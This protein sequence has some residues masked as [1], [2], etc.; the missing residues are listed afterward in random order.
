MIE[1]NTGFVP[2][3]LFIPVEQRTTEN[4][5]IVGGDIRSLDQI[6]GVWYVFLGL[7]PNGLSAFEDRRVVRGAP[8]LA[9]NLEAITALGRPDLIVIPEDADLLWS[10]FERLSRAIDPEY[11]GLFHFA[12]NDSP[13][14]LDCQLQIR[15][16]PWSVF[17]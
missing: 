2:N 14:G 3:N 10:M 17:K 1:F 8:I 9:R 4:T 15:S 12:F 11:G 16:V 6:N 13:D 5:A 7:F